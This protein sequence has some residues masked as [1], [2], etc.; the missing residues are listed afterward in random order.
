MSSL[1]IVQMENM[2]KFILNVVQSSEADN[3]VQ[4]NPREVLSICFIE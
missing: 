1:T 2:G 3:Y 4:L